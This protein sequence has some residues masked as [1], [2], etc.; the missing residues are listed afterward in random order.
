MLVDDV[1]AVR[2][3]CCAPRCELLA[4]GVDVG[5]QLHAWAART[6]G[7][8]RRRSSAASKRAGWLGVG[9]GSFMHAPPL[10]ASGTMLDLLTADRP[11]SHPWYISAMAAS[12]SSHRPD[13]LGFVFRDHVLP[14]FAPAFDR[15]G[16]AT[17]HE[18]NAYWFAQNTSVPLAAFEPAFAAKMRDPSSAERRGAAAALARESDLTPATWTPRA[19][20]HLCGGVDDE[21]VPFASLRA[22]DAWGITLIATAGGHVDGIAECHKIALENLTAAACGRR[23]ALAAAAA[24]RARHGVRACRG[25]AAA[26]RIAELGP[27][28]ILVYA[29]AA[30][31]ALWLAW[32]LFRLVRWFARGRC[33]TRPVASPPVQPA[34]AW[35]AAC[36]RARTTHRERLLVQRCRRGHDATKAAPPL[37]P[38]PR[39]LRWVARSPRRA[40]ATLRA[41]RRRRS[42]R[43]RAHH[44]RRAPV[45]L[46]LA[47]FRVT[48]GTYTDRLDARVGR[49]CPSGHD[50]ASG[51]GRRGDADG[52]VGARGEACLDGWRRCTWWRPTYSRWWR[53]AP[54]TT[55]SLPTRARWRRAG[56]ASAAAPSATGRRRAC[57]DA[58]SSDAAAVR[59]GVVRWGDA[60]V[61][62]AGRRREHGGALALSR[63]DGLR[64]R[65]SQQP[66]MAG[67]GRL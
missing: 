54:M 59:G 26:G 43:I 19:L 42:R 15:I 49:R 63:R 20:Q 44:R 21:Q 64:D 5:R 40:V 45:A 2:S 36:R 30:A 4:S 39:V 3:L 1:A 28:S 52:C 58:G 61:C 41:L 6:A 50:V 57:E 11:F 47:S 53:R 9:L 16:D 17:S 55:G 22:A 7:N 62:A 48:E 38:P 29:V 14:A 46:D 31:L 24:R 10:D 51:D 18:L 60:A 33:I 32:S 34:S 37:P 27:P 67:V 66:R 65:D 35:C 13:A 8:E 56:P 12:Y 23:A 25:A